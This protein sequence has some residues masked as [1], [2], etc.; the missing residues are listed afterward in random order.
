MVKIPFSIHNEQF[1]LEKIKGKQEF[2]PKEIAMLFLKDGQITFS[3]NGV[4]QH[5]SP[6]SILFI[7]PRN[8]Y[9]LEDITTN[10]KLFVIGIYPESRNYFRYNFN[11]FN[12]YQALKGEKND[13]IEI[14]EEEIENFWG[15][16]EFMHYISQKNDKAY[17]EEIIAHLFNVVSYSM[18][19]Y[20]ESKIIRSKNNPE[21]NIRKEE[22]TLKFLDLASRHFLEEKELKFYADNLSISIKYLSICVK[23]IS[24]HPP[25]YFINQFLIEE[26]CKRLADNKFSVADV[27][28]DLGFADQFI[29]SKFFK[30]H[31]KQTPTQFRK[32]I[33]QVYTI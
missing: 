33:D 13:S 1:L 19:S 26:A 18:V 24:G 31:S 14:P 4:S 28:F 22:I 2:Y 7:S 12:V 11:R 25:T 17:R 21:S 5:Y 8:I 3:V 15:V 20:I 29:F 32:R 6:N 27:A 16:L 10:I 23:E 9:R 30:K